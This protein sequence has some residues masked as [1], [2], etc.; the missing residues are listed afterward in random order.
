MKKCLGNGPKANKAICGT[1]EA[2]TV[3]KCRYFLTIFDGDPLPW[4]RFLLLFN[5][6]KLLC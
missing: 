5:D 2:H 1:Y 4:R 6:S 3:R